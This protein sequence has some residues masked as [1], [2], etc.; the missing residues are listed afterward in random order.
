MDKRTPV[1]LNKEPLLEALWEIRFAGTRPSML[2]LL[3]GQIYKILS[4]RYTDIVRLPA[5][6][7]P[8]PISEH[9]PSLKYVPRVRLEGGSYA[10]QIGEHVVSLSCRRPYSG[11]ELFSREIRD[12]VGVLNRSALIEH[13]E[14][15]SLKYIDLIQLKQP[16]DLTCLNIDLKL[17]GHQIDVSPIHLRS[18]IREESLFHIIQIVSPAQV[19]LQGDQKLVGVLLDVDTI[20]PIGSWGDVDDRLDMAHSASKRMFF[21][22]L[23]RETIEKLEPEYKE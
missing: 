20:H 4:D 10:I 2:E 7:I 11:W 13:L 22:L 16:P 3:F 1:R 15:F 5:A 8:S 17:G 18:E 23:T 19:T 12:L 21:D 14:R 6:D 9:D